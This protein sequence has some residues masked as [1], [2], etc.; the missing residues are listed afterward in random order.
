LNFSLVKLIHRFT[1]AKFRE[2][3]AV[4]GGV[5]LAK[6]QAEVEPM[7]DAWLIRK[8]LVG[9]AWATWLAVLGLLLVVGLQTWGLTVWAAAE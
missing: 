7:I 1:L 3:N 2:E 5:D 6:V 8:L 9:V 4:S